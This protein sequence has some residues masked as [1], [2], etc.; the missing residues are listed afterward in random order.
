MNKNTSR[1]AKSILICLF[2]FGLLLTGIYF[3]NNTAKQEP[4]Y[5]EVVAMFKNN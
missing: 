2:T 3:M 5:S 4:K 1:N